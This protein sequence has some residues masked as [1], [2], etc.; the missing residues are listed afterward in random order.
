MSTYSH[1]QPS[2]NLLYFGILAAVFGLV[3]I[4][5]PGLT[6]FTFFIIWG[7][8]ALC[9]GIASLLLAPR[10]ERLRSLLI[11]KGIVGVLAGIL[12]IFRPGIG[13]ATAVWMLGFWLILRGIFDGVNAFSTKEVK[14]KVLN[15]LVAALWVLAGVVV[16]SN[17]GATA[18]GIMVWLGSFAL[19][20]G[21]ISITTY[22]LSRKRN[23]S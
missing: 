11:T 5:W 23:L 17:P 6:V 15:F 12:V 7:V 3:A 9:D 10:D 13:V 4:F 19:L 16:M 8:F 18:I 1:T 14:Q 22:A 20:G 21:I 2:K